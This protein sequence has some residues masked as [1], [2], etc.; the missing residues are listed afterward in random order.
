[1]PI[2][3]MAALK[4]ARAAADTATLI[5]GAKGVYTIID[6]FDTVLDSA[7]LA[8]EIARAAM[9]DNYDPAIKELSE[10]VILAGKKYDSYLV[11]IIKANDTLDNLKDGI[12][13]LKDIHKDM[14]TKNE[15]IFSQMEKLQALKEQL[16]TV[17]PTSYKWFDSIPTQMTKKKF[18]ASKVN[19][20]KALMGPN[21]TE[22]G[23][24]TGSLAIRAAMFSYSKYTNRPPTPSSER[25]N[26]TSDIF[27]GVSPEEVRK[28]RKIYDTNTKTLKQKVMT[29]GKL[30]AGGVHKIVTVGSFAMNIYGL[31]SKVN[32]RQKVFDEFTR[33]LAQYNQENNYYEWAL[34]GTENSDNLS[35][36]KTFF[37]LTDN[38]NSADEAL[39]AGYNGIIGEYERDIAQLLN[40]PSEDEIDVGSYDSAYT[41]AINSFKQADVS[42][43][44]SSVLVNLEKSY[45]KFK[46]YRAIAL[47]KSKSSATRKDD[48]LDNIRDEFIS[49]VVDHVNEIQ[50]ILDIFIAN[51]LAFSTVKTVAE[52]FYTKEKNIA[53]TERAD[54]KEI[55]PD[56]SEERLNIAVAKKVKIHQESIGDKAVFAFELIQ[57]DIDIRNKLKTE[58]EVKDLMLQLV[59]EYRNGPIA[60]ESS[61]QKPK[62]FNWTTQ[63][64]GVIKVQPNNDDSV[65]LE[66]SLSGSSV[67]TQQTWLYQATAEETGTLSFDWEYSGFHAWYRP[68]LV[69][70]VFSDTAEGRNTTT[71]LE[72]NTREGKGSTSID[73]VKGE[74]L[75]FIIK[76]SNYDSDSRL[77][78]FLKV[79]FSA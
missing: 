33:M 27:E 23:I 52:N 64:P 74:K 46:G 4:A 48:G 45:E 28:Y 66:Y 15:V 40:K 25:R 70:S 29:T 37:Q 9:G 10:K 54:Y 56:I 69:L 76:G 21:Y 3:F 24:I 38:G 13:S 19:D 35:A 22:I 20:L 49:S 39:K 61:A 30:I 75:G 11:D 2:K 67:W 32:T 16:L 58:Q 72:G 78:G 68:T 18:D 55:F 79:K 65:T 44:E 14:D 1:M 77:L 36:L 60:Q 71:L 57:T 31:V 6:V 5:K 51:D 53:I 43:E 63:G 26:A 34:N 17:S 62:K 41:S 8:D 7:Q 50:N 42:I 59:A 73:V 12:D 47:D